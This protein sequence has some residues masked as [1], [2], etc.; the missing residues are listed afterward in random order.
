M[1]KLSHE[2]GKES[3]PQTLSQ[4]AAEAGFHFEA[5]PPALPNPPAVPW[6]ACE[7]CF[8]GETERPPASFVV[9]G[10]SHLIVSLCGLDSLLP[11]VMGG[12]SQD[13]G[14]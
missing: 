5:C 1:R 13:W 8:Y 3:C 2:Q 10:L 7:G 4:Q 12:D 9:W 11:P 6:T 14:K